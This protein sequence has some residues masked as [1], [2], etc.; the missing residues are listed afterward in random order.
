[1]TRRPEIDEGD[2]LLAC[3][4]ALCDLSIASAKLAKT[5]F[6]GAMMLAEKLEEKPDA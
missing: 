2:E 5:A 1:M 3:I 4:E 6:N